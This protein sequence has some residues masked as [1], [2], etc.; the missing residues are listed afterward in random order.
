[1]RED[2]KW[3]ELGA[4]KSGSSKDKD[5]A[6]KIPPSDGMS[7][8]AMNPGSPSPAVS[9]NKNGNRRRENRMYADLNGEQLLQMPPDERYKEILKMSPQERMD[10]ARTYRGP[11]AM[12]LVD[13]MKPEQQETV[14]AIVNPQVVVGGELSA[15]KLLRDIY[16]ERQLDEVMADFWFNHFNVFIGKGPDRYMLTTHEREVI[17]PHAL[18]KFKDLL[19]ATAKSP[20]MLFYLDNWQSVGPNSDLAKYGPQGKNP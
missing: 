4:A 2:A 1:M 11:R 16:S 7:D 8:A 14:E 3:A 6:G 15:A 20:A 5:A 10:L 12:Q 13:G 19:A 9:Q 18:G 17:R